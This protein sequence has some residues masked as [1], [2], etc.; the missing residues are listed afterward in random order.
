M[1]D[2]NQIDQAQK[3]ALAMGGVDNMPVFERLGIIVRVLH[4]TLCE[5]GAEDVLVD[6]ASE[7]PTARQR[8]VHIAELT[9]NAANLVL[10]KVEQHSPVLDTLASTA[11]RLGSAWDAAQSATPD[12]AQLVLDTRTFLSKVKTD[13]NAT[14]GALSDIMMAQD[15]QDL[16]GQLI[17]KIVTVMER[18]EN[19][20]LALLIDAAPAGLLVA[21]HQDEEM[22]GPGAHGSRALDQACVDDLLADLGF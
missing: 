11:T 19:D 3:N 6:A 4:D 8:L 13:C 20:L 9:E 10:G 21:E 16:T 15:F 22:A 2:I 1:H 12:N 5:I 17:K 14:H 18:T 7:F